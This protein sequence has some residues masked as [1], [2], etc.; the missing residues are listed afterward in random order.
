MVANNNDATTISQDG[1]IQAANLLGIGIATCY[2][3][4]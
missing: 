2:P 4:S 3:A 1:D